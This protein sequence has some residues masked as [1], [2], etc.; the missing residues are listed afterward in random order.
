M[1]SVKQKLSDRAAAILLGLIERHIATSEPVGAKALAEK[2]SFHLSAASIRNVMAELEA[3]GYLLSPHQSAGRVP[4]DRGYRLYVDSL[5][6]PVGLSQGDLQTVQ[7]I[8][9]NSEWREMALLLTA[10]SRALAALS[11][12]VALVELHHF[13]ATVR[14]IHFVRVGRGLAQAVIVTTAT[15]VENRIIATDPD[16]DQERLNRLSN[17]FND[18]FSGFSLPQI[19]RKLM[20]EALRDRTNADMLARWATTMAEELERSGETQSGGVIFINGA[21]NLL[22]ITKSGPDMARVRAL[23]AALD[24]KNRIME[25]VMELLQ[26]DGVTTRIGGESGVD[27]LNDFSIVSHP[28]AGQKEAMGLIGIIGPKTMNYGRAG[29]LV[30]ATAREMSRRLVGNTL[31]QE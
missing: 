26:S 23:I 27:E 15:D 6:R 5:M 1:P 2:R 4:S 18:R 25:L 24:E 12:Q 10:V 21:R 3:D 13:D 7:D 16:F 11:A 29:A 17:Y 19:R 22:N 9:Q 8:T 31:T 14:S 28:L 30:T 20:D